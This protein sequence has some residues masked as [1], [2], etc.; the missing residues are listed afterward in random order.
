MADYCVSCFGGRLQVL[1]PCCRILTPF[2][3]SWLLPFQA[4]A[5]LEQEQRQFDQASL[6]YVCLLQEVQQRKKFEFVETVGI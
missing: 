6:D 3:D 2:A 1:T 5:S 4:D